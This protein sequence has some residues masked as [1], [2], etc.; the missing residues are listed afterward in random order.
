MMPEKIK[1]VTE[2]EIDIS[3]FKPSDFYHSVDEEVI[4]SE[5][6][7]GLFPRRHLSI[8]ASK[9]GVGKTWYLCKLIADLTR[10]GTIFIQQAFDEPPRKVLF[11][12]GETNVNLINERFSLMADEVYSNNLKIISYLE[13]AVRGQFLD[14]DTK[15]GATR[16]SAV[17]KDFQPDLVIFDTMMSFRRDDENSAQSTR[18]LCA[19]LQSLAENNNCAVI[20]THH[21]RKADK[22]EKAM[23]ELD[24]DEIIGSSALVRMAGTA[25]IMTKRYK[26]VKLT[27]VKSWW[28]VPPV[29]L[30]EMKEA[31]GKM[32]FELAEI[33]DDITEARLR[34]ERWI[35]QQQDRGATFSTAD[36]MRENKVGHSTASAAIKN[37]GCKISHKVNNVTYY[38]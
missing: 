24:Q 12:V 38:R 32:Y 9:S 13:T 34:A 15:L 36:V 37:K 23:S 25:F 1:V 17:V 27:C 14:L 5:F 26:A 16:I 6:I 35:V 3:D 20:A 31:D 21:L 19:R 22:R 8:I 28:K 2:R 18:D 10:G 7:G 30:Y 33:S 4:A 29:F 11:F